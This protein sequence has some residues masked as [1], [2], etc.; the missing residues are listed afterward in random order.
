MSMSDMHRHATDRI[1]MRTS[2]ALLSAD[3]VNSVARFLARSYGLICAA[4]VPL[5][6]IAERSR[7]ADTV[8]TAGRLQKVLT[9]A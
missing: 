1:T 3:P 9:A 6:L 2:N 5:N 4:V 7:A 8:H